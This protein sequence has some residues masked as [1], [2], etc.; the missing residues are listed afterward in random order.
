M[1]STP[2]R[3]LAHRPPPPPAQRAK[4]VDPAAPPV[5]QRP[6]RATPRAGT[7]SAARRVARLRIRPALPSD[8]VPLQF[9]FDTAL[10]RDYFLRRG[11]LEYLIRS[12]NHRVLVAA[13]DSVLVGAAILTRGTRLVNVL[14]HPSYRNLG[15]G[16]Q[17]VQDS[18]AAE[19]R[20]KLD[21]SGGDPTGFYESLGFEPT[22]VR[23]AKGNVRLMARRGAAIRSAN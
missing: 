15:I 19:V 8:L 6:A 18:G 13:I 21:M 7:A 11:Q 14:V 17:L 3:S 23:N 9:F 12:R 16:R 4:P 2:A 20:V 1:T 10:R 22:P 5:P